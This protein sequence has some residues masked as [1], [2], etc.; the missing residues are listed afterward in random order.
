VPITIPHPAGHKEKIFLVGEI[1]LII[2]RPALESENLGL[3]EVSTGKVIEVFDLKTT[4]DDQYWRKTLGQ[5]IFYEIAVW[6]MTRQWPV[7]SGLLQPLCQ[8]TQPVWRFTMEHRTQMLQRIVVTA[9]DI[10]AGRLDPNPDKHLCG[11]CSVRHACPL[12]GGGRGRVIMAMP[13]PGS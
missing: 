13:V 2:R 11:Y 9:G 10:W 1:D 5:L 6:G 8:E 12:K 3:G 7:L 4:R